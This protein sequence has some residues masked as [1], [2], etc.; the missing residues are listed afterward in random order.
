[1]FLKIFL[2]SS[3][4]GFGLCS[5]LCEMWVRISFFVFAFF[6]IVAASFAVKCRYSFAFAFSFCVKEASQISKSEFFAK[7]IAFW[8]IDVSR[9]NVT[10][11]PFSKYVT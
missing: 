9:M 3:K 6:A 2:A 11:L 5:Y 8:L 10:F 4:I 1:V 7:V